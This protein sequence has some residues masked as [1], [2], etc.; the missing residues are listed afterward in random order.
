MRAAVSAIR[1]I[2]Y[3]GI[4]RQSLQVVRSVLLQLA[5]RRELFP[6]STFPAVANQQN[7]YPLY[8]LS[9]DEDHRF[10]LYL[11]SSKGRNEVPP[12]DHKTWAVT[13]SVVGTEENR[14]YEPEKENFHPYK[15]TLK[16]VG[17]Q[18][19]RPGV[20][21]CLMPYDVHSVHAF[22]QETALILHMYGKAL[23]H[24]P[25]RTTFDLESATYRTGLPGLHIVEAR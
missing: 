15:G 17:S 23:D 13:V 11:N 9:E 16:L 22:N 5:T 1:D 7:L 8:R 25:D 19:V 3:S 18:T 6:E 20:G 24:L 2:E 21:L 14:F 10:A 12:H 4:S